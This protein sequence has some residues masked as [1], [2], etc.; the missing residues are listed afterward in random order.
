MPRTLAVHPSHRDRLAVALERNGFLTQGDLAI[1]LEIAAST[2]SNFFRGVRVSVA[3]FE[4]IAEAL[5]LDPRELMLEKGKRKAEKGREKMEEGKGEEDRLE[6]LRGSFFSYD[7]A[8]AGREE[9]VTELGQV[10]QGSCRLLLIVGIAGIGKTALGERLCWELAQETETALPVLRLNFDR[11]DP[12]PDFTRAALS[13]LEAADE[14]VPLEE[15]A[16]PDALGDRLLALLQEKPYWVVIDSLEELLQG[17]AET[18]WSEFQDAQ[19]LKFFTQV[20]SRPDFAS[21]LL[22]T[23]QEL[24]ASVVA[25]GTRYQNFWHCQLLQGL[26]EPEYLDLFEKTG[27]ETASATVKDALR[28]IGQAYEGHP[29]ALR[30]VA[31]EMGT[32]PFFGRVDAYWQRYGVEFERVERALAEAKAGVVMGAEDLWRLDRFTRALRRNV[33]ERLEQTLERLQRDSDAAY[34]LLC[35]ASVYRCGVPEGFWLSHLD[36]WQVPPEEQG[37]ALDVLR[38]RFLLEEVLEQDE[39]LVRQHHLVRSVGLDHLRR[40]DEGAEK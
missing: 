40:W 17:S 10:L 26:M 31:G 28:R 29:L 4:A 38:D 13:L 24:P 36:F 8:W 7:S 2:V 20:L 9:L 14:W 22:V 21:T 27:L 5:N 11:Q 19:F 6:K 15:R 30:V 3:K 37:L 32:A 12:N 23:S 35:E 1:H 16:N 39:V 34:R 25:M 33:R 18:G